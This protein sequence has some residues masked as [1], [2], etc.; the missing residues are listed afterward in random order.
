MDKVKLLNPLD[1]SVSATNGSFGSEWILIDRA[2]IHKGRDSGGILNF[3][4][5][6]DLRL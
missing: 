5:R 2:G 6:R 4:L 1:L 3:R